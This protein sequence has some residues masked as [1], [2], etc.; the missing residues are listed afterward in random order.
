M[1]RI[2]QSDLI[3]EAHQKLVKIIKIIEQNYGR[4]FITPNLHLSLHLQECVQ[5]YGP[6]YAFWCFSFERI[7]GVLGKL[8][9]ENLWQISSFLWTVYF[10]GSLPNS[11]RKIEPELMRRIMNDNQINNIIGSGAATKGLDILDT[12]PSVGS[13]SDN[14]EFSLEE[15]EWFLL[16]SQN[17]KE[18]PIYGYE[19]FSG[20]MLSPSSE[21][22]L[23]SNEMLNIMVEYYKATY[24]RYKFWRPFGEGPDDSII[25]R[26]RMS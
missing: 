18:S 9:F 20:E 7:N 24:I 13:I 12:R 16:Y 22:I 19:V 11:H 2:I 4:D 23:M 3:E 21:N 5:D 26:V 15:M 1:R 8:I 25:I 14:D 6:L 10:L 17:I